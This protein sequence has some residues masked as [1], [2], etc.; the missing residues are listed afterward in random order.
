[1]VADNGNVSS[2]YSECLHSLSS[3]E[4]K[5]K[6]LHDQLEETIKLQ[7]AGKYCFNISCLFGLHTVD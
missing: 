7:D 1:M 3:E 6:A 4:N 2:K 5:F